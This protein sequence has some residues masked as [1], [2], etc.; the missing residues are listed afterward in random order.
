MKPAL[1]ALALF[2]AAAPAKHV[3]PPAKHA[4]PAAKVAPAPAVPKPVLP[5]DLYA[6]GKYEEAI[7][8]GTAQN[9]GQ[10]YAV[11][12][13]A[14]LAIANERPSPCI[15]C[16]KR[17]EALAR[18][19]IA[20]NDRLADPRVYL[21]VSLGYQS[22]IAGVVVAKLRG[23]P[24]EAKAQ[25]DKAIALDPNNA[26]A[27]AARGG[28]NIEVVRAGGSY[29]AKLI[30]GATVTGGLADLSKAFRVDPTNIAIRY[31]FA[32]LLA[33]LDIDTYRKAVEEILRKVVKSK[34][35]TEYENFARGRA[36]EL[37]DCLRDDNMA[38]FK[39]LLKRDQGYP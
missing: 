16:L 1:L 33:G 10:G 13:R 24:D 7:R 29:L 2:A 18:K 11:A 25:L 34:P 19:A 37:I 23:Y 14:A 38:E 12:A 9:D 20:T 36:Q 21:A 8:L 5:Y 15:E 6:A 17:A 32:L 27:L 28:W 3:V 30:Y 26:W 4:A 35:A 22:R 39:R 31:Q